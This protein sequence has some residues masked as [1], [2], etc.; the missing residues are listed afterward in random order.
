MADANF[1]A[2][3]AGLIAIDK[4]ANHVL[5]LDPVTYDTELTLDGF[6]PKSRLTGG[7][8]MCP[9]TAMASTATT[10]IRGT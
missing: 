9:S 4:V 5:F 6:A 3:S 7:S 8:R 1:L 2:G 10:R